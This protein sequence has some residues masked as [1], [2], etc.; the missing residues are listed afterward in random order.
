MKTALV[1][2]AF[3]PLALQDKPAATMKAVRIHE[4]GKPEVLVYE[5]APR[6]EPKPS[7]VLVKVH[8]AG[9]N[10]VDWK[11]RGGAFGK[12][13]SPLPMI[14]GG[15]IA[16]TVESCGAEV[17]GFKP[18]DEVWALLPLMRMGGYAEYAVVAESDLARKP[19]SIDFVHA[20]GVP[21]AA[22]TAWQAL[23][24]TAG[25]KEGQSVLIHAG[26]GG[27]GHF[28]I[29]IA[30]AKGAKVIATA[31][32]NHLAFLKELGA[33][34]AIDYKAQKFEE[35]AKDVDVV[36]DSIGGDTQA[37]SLGCLKKGGFLVSIV[38]PPDK[39]KLDELG[40]K[41]AII[42]VKPN[43][44]ELDELAKLVE[45]KK[46]KCVVSATVPLA[47]ARKAHEQSETGHT[48]GKIVLQVVK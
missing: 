39:G 37:R 44:K 36:L 35:L 5:D 2:L 48:Q 26:A 40:L 32:E 19:K 13:K 47:D 10:P 8:A 43:V 24:D 4:F 30:K 9:V 23:V 41:G 18:G 46:L 15:E 17:K 16:G 28:A 29:Q 33:D 3:L 27:V 45:D 31:S 11:I 7:E 25:L 1:L 42:L 21:L 20:A 38:Q 6:P 34:V 14:L 22:L 12:G